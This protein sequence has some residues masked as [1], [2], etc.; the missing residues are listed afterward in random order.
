MVSGTKMTP[1]DF[2]Q[3]S[4]TWTNT[5]PQEWLH[6]RQQH[7]DGSSEGVHGDLHPECEHAQVHLKQNSGT[8]VPGRL[9]VLLDLGSKINIIGSATERTFAAE[10]AK[11]NVTNTYR[12]RE[13]RLHVSG[14]GTDSAFCDQ[15]PFQ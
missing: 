5:T 9:S 7:N 6:Q 11:Y 3:W 12:P 10:I 2:A 15:E 1:G 13:H 8:K 4:R 14:V